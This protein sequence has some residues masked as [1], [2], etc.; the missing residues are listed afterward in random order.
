VEALVR[1]FA[2]GFGMRMLKYLFLEED[3]E[4][5]NRIRDRLWTS[6]LCGV[7]MSAFI[8]GATLFLPTRLSL[9]SVCIIFCL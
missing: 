7:S 6:T 2:L 8:F 4:S 5:L 1:G 9:S 3:G